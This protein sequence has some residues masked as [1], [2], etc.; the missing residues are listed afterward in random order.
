MNFNVYLDT[1]TVTRLNTLARQRGTTRNALIR[2]AVAQLLEGDGGQAWPESVKAFE[3]V[4]DAPRFE[5]SRRKLRA[6]R[7]DPL[8]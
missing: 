5:A 6:P 3:G 2:E 7:K 1:E 8:R 4:P